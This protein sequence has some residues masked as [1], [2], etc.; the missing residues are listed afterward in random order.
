M[1]L[2]LRDDP[3]DPLQAPGQTLGNRPRPC[4]T[5]AAVAVADTAAPGDAA[6]PAHA[7]TEEPRFAIVPPV[8]ARPVSRP[9]SPQRLRFVL[10]G[11]IAG[12][13]GGALRPPRG[14]DG[15]DLQGLESHGTKLGVEMGRTQ[16]IEAVPQPVIIAGGT[17]EPCLQ[18]GPHP[19]LFEPSPDF[20]EG[21]RPVQNRAH[22][23]FDSTPTREPM[24]RVR[25]AETVNDRGD[26]QTP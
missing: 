18:Q 15:I 26:L 22:Q 14:R 10:I 12:K 13:R 6:I 16:R 19:T 2:P 9:R 8:F 7:K 23:G 20:R 17:G 1:R 5:I 24:G 25:R 3:T 11:P 21:M 4:Y